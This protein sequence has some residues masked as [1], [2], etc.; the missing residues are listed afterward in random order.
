MAPAAPPP[1]Q[2]AALSSLRRAPQGR[3]SALSATGL[4]A[5]ASRFLVSLCEGF[6]DK[7]RCI[8]GWQRVLAVAGEG[9][10]YDS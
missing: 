8:N 6:R 7:E 3:L 9:M 4:S 5:A 2:L 1:A 10:I